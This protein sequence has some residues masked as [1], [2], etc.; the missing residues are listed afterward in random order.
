MVKKLKKMNVNQLGEVFNFDKDFEKNSRL[1]SLG[2]IIGKKIKILEKNKDT[3][4]IMCGRET[5]AL[6]IEL[7]GELEVKICH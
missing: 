5:I 3:L 6:D 4:I 7:I 1:F 2:I